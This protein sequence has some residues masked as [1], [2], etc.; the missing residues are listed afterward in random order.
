MSSSSSSSSPAGSVAL[1][2]AAAAAAVFCHAQRQRP[3]AVADRTAASQARRLARLAKRWRQELWHSIVPFWMAHG[4]DEE[5]GGFFTS[6]DRR[7]EVLVDAKYHWLQGRAVWTSSRLCR[8]LLSASAA[9]GGTT[10]EGSG[11][12]SEEMSEGEADRLLHAAHNGAKFLRF[13]KEGSFVGM[14]MLGAGGGRDDTDNEDGTGGS[15][16][17]VFFSTTRDGWPTHVQRKP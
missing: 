16:N 2:G 15:N 11:R 7:G 12:H 1:F 13:A 17:P 8:R 5:C 4:V 10:A 14:F 3:H 6:L 9:G